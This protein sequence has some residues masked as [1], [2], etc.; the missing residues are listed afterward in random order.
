MEG[1]AHISQKGLQGAGLQDVKEIQKPQK[2]PDMQKSACKG[3][4]IR[5]FAFSTN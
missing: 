1:E 4:E 2:F 5:N 3:P